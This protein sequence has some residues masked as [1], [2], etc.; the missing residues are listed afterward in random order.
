MCGVFALVADDVAEPIIQAL[1][2]LQHRGQDAAG[3]FLYNHHTK[4][5]YLKKDLG[6]V[7]KV[8]PDGEIYP[9]ATMGIGHVRYSTI[10]KG[11]AEDAQ[12]LYAQAKTHVAIAHNGNIVNYVPLR[13]QLEDH[14]SAF[15]SLCDV[16]VILHQC[17]HQ[18][19]T[20]TFEDLCTA[21]RYVFDT[22][23]GAYSVVMIVEGLGLVAFRDPHGIRPLAYGVR[24]EDNAHGFAS[25][26]S[27]LQ[28]LDF[29]HFEDV[30]PGEVVLVTQERKVLRRQLTHKSHNHCSFEYD[31]FAKPNAILDA[32]EVYRVRARLGEA[33]G[34]KIKQ[35][36]LQADVVVPIPDT[37]R[38][39]ALALAQT[40]QVPLEDGFVKQGYVGRTFIMP[41]QNLRKRA[42]HQ[43]LA[44]V[45]SVF[46][47]KN[48]IIVD[49]SIVRGTVSKRVVRLARAA[50][51]Q[52]VY[53]ASTFPAIRHMCAYGVDFPDPQQLIAFGKTDEEIC[54]EIEA[55]G[56]IFNDISRFQESIGSS[57]LCLACLTGDYPTKMDG[58]EE[59][60]NLRDKNIRE[61]ELVCQH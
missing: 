6:L 52:K 24:R 55:D 1:I 33:L 36:N 57:K 46:A 11:N 29:D 20:P 48:V 21:V 31:Y 26:T 27:P 50:G 38:P 17:L 61:M 5:H 2:Q 9:E 53:F 34:H 28:L 47:G 15:T 22:T 7:S 37:A 19:A 35:S 51:A 54:H 14:G 44:S 41:T 16:E 25:E 43:K 13:Q 30:T 8:F 45:S 3:I 56:L 4:K 12:P 39:A 59:L 42:V 58:L 49:D 23:F 10:G 60:Q 32:H 40:I 18:L